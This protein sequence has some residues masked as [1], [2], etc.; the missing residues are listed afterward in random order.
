MRFGEFFAAKPK[1]DYSSMFVE[2]T[3]DHVAA[4]ANV[5]DGGISVST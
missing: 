4:Y 2:A 1:I 3:N 5:V